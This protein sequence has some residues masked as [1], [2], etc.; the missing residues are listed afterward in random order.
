MYHFPKLVSAVTTVI[1]TFAYSIS[2]YSLNP[3]FFSA[4][5]DRQDLS[6]LTT[7][8]PVFFGV[9]AIQALHEAAHYFVAKR[10]GIKVGIPVPLPSF[11]VG[12]FG[13]ITPLRSFPAS[14]T[15]L[16]DFA[17]S[18]PLVG[19]LASMGLMA[20]GVL[21]TV[22]ASS[23]AL[24]GFPVVPVALLKAS[25][26]VGSL[27][28]MLAPKTMIL[29]ASQPVPVHPFF[30]IGFAGLITNALNLL[31]LGRLDGGRAYTAIFGSRNASLA[32]LLTLIL[33]ALLSLS[34]MSN[35]SIF[36]G[37]FVV[38]FQRQAEIPVRNEVTEVDDVRVGVYVI[39]LLLTILALA[40]FPGGH[41]ML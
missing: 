5:V 35:I 19:L 37:T 26:F 20:G 1:T 10:A 31:P 7:C 23:E 11:Q 9:L 32:S 39:S 25:Y 22:Y 18:G 33:M 4:V 27:L 15:S 8:L 29:P 40:P 13:S 2:C 16:L 21:A 6:V 28:S 17:L 41:G 30:M 34:G 3:D 12:S 38:L 36:W 24:L 14:R